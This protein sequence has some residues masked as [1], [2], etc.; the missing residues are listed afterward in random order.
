M[1]TSTG[2]S[3]VK[4]VIQLLSRGKIRRE[5][6]EYVVEGA[7][8]VAEVPASSLVKVYLSETY[9]K[10]NGNVYGARA[11]V[12]SDNVYNHMSDT[13]TPQGIMA[14][15]KMQEYGLE[16]LLS[17]SNAPLVLCVENLQDPGNLGTIIR[18]GEAAG[19][20]GVLI[21]GNSVDIY[22]PKVIRSTMGS[23]FRV[24]HLIVDDF[25]GTLDELKNNGI[26]IYAAH[27]DGKLSYTDADYTGGTA[28][29][30]G[31]EGNGLTEEAAS[32][33]DCLVKIPMHGAVESL[34]A[35]IAC[36]VLAFE[37]SRQRA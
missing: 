34:N 26:K 35:A 23:V 33:A 2:S 3:Q 24:P 36:T 21:S 1:I 29:I 19:A 37:A 4:H 5:S 16:D 32:K 25:T 28:F 13:K 6:K 11:E 12:V 10:N 17:G 14:V 20:S 22:N 15:V 9:A 8:M 31:N 18:M 27:L 7:R 30:I